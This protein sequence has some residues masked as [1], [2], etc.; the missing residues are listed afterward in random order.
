M[1]DIGALCQRPEVSNLFGSCMR[2]GSLAFAAE[3][4]EESWANC[5][6]QKRSTIL[7]GSNRQQTSDPMT[8]MIL[9]Q[10]ARMFPAMVE[11]CIK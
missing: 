1:W 10:V 9:Q 6:E 11:L 7:D 3:A 8:L 4:W 2:S 5:E